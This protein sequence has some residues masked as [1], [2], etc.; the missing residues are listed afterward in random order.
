M[1]EIKITRKRVYVIGAVLGALFLIYLMAR[2]CGNDENLVYD[3]ESITIGRVKKTISVTGTLE[4]LHSYTVASKIS[5]MV[6]QVLVDFN[7]RVGKGQLLATID[8]SEIDQNLLKMSAK[9]EIAKLELQS[10]KQDLAGKKNLFKDNL[11]SKKEM[12]RAELQYKQILSQHKQILIDYNIAV[13]NKSYSRI[14]SPTNGIVIAREI[15]PYMMVS[16]KKVLF[17][18]A[19][20]LK[21][22]RLIISVD[23][24]DIGY[25]ENGQNVSFTVS[26]YP[27]KTFTGTI[28]QVRFN[29]ITKGE[30]VT[31]ES[32]VLC[33][34]SKLLLKPGMTAT[35]TIEVVNKDGVLRVPNQ[36][37]IVSPVEVKEMSM[38]KFVW[39]KEDLPLGKLPVRRV[40]IKTGIMG[41]HYAEFLS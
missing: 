18:V 32:V 35:A 7:Q 21:K 1:P 8:S 41:D 40:K 6:T 19:E 9:L 5:G 4:V 37:L 3:Y 2:G 30:V 23:E 26:A 34:N 39:V 33:D 36:A 15:D 17:V 16:E 20:S 22:M 25:I 29:P 14:T 11:I 28:D 12:E 10:A 27:E 31:Y 13:K 38:G 24:T